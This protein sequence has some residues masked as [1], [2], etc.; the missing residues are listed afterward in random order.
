MTNITIENFGAQTAF[1]MAYAVYL[2]NSYRIQIDG[3]TIIDTLDLFG[4]GVLHVGVALYGSISNVRI[5]STGSPTTPI[6]LDSIYGGLLSGI[7][8]P[9]GSPKIDAYTDQ[10]YIN[11]WTFVNC[12]GMFT[13]KRTI[14]TGCVISA[15]KTLADDATPSVAGANLFLTGGVTTITDFDDGGV[16]QVITIIA[17]HAITITDGTNIFLSGSANF[18]MAITDTLT[19]VQKADG[20]WYEIGRSDNT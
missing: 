9:T 12:D 8:V 16:G 17:E 19:L 4:T 7:Q 3:L 5:L 15:I 18:V 14:S 13:D 20:L 1:P 2:Q 11:G 10:A 6:V